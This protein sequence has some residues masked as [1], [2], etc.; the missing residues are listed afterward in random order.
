MIF[1]SGNLVYRDFADIGVVSADND[2]SQ[3]RTSPTLKACLKPCPHW[4][5]YS[6]RI[7]RLSPFSVT[8]AKFG[9]AVFGASVERA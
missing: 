4:R 9:V 2:L 6:R 8:V 3:S 7:R 5:L 1:F